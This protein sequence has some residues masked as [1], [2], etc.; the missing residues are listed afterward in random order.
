MD[1][2]ELFPKQRAPE[3]RDII[4]Y[5]GGE[6]SELWIALIE[7]MESAYGAKPKLSFSGCSMKPGWN[8]KY[9]KSGQ[10]FGTLYP[11]EGAFSVFIVMSYKL[12]N[13]VDAAPL[14]DD[15]RARWAVAQDYMKLG[16]FMMFAIK[17]R[18]ALDDYIA[19]MSV[20]RAP[21]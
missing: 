15:M 17:T 8:V 13:E 18:E 10:N 20:K 9:S 3:M 5:I 1:W 12:A 16:R 11:E 14:S 4:D 19:L 21:L 2:M 7:Y 6:A